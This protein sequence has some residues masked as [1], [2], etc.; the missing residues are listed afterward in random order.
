M[1]APLGS[2]FA[3]AVRMI[4][5]IHRGTT[6]MRT[7]AEPAIAAGLADHDR[8]M[9]RIANRANRRSAGGR[10]TSDFAAG[11]IDL[12]PVRLASGER[13]RD[14]GRTAEDSAASW[15]QLDA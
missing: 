9:L 8:L 5:G 14:A 12:S 4:D 11:K 10:N 1:P 13:S 2:A 7:P 6:H 15:L 3:T